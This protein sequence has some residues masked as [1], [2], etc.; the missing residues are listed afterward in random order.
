MP[1]ADPETGRNT[2]NSTNGASSSGQPNF[3]GIKL[4]PFVTDGQLQI[5][6]ERLCASV[7]ESSDPFW[8]SND[9]WI[10]CTGI[11]SLGSYSSDSKLR[12]IE[13]T[14]KVVGRPGLEPWDVYLQNK[15]AI[16]RAVAEV[17]KCG[18]LRVESVKFTK[19]S[20]TIALVLAIVQAAIGIGGI[21]VAV[22][23]LLARYPQVKRGF[24]DMIVD[25]EALNKKLSARL[26]NFFFGFSGA[27]A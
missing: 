3:G 4:P 27:G 6:R 23:D 2:Q 18:Q 5:A 25:L 8:S 20:V 21:V 15:E 22:L 24:E 16:E 17:A 12:D 11:E 14:L 19:G 9:Y 7:P 10:G 1:I 13:V 26:S